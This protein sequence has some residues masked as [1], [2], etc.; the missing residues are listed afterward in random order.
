[1]AQTATY[2]ATG[3][4]KTS[5]ARVILRPGS[6]DMTVNGRPLRRPGTPLDRH[7]AA[8]EQQLVAPLEQAGVRPGDVEGAVEP[9]RPADVAGEQR[10]TRRCR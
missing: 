2:R 6:G 8:V 5:V 1:M 9:V 4:R 7:G 10:L 3:K